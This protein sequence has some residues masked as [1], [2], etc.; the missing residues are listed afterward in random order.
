[1]EGG[2]LAKYGL[3]VGHAGPPVAVLLVRVSHKQGV[4]L[5]VYAD[6]AGVLAAGGAVAHGGGFALPVLSAGAVVRS[7]ALPKVSSMSL[8]CAA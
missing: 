6:V 3:D 4:Q 2:T 5:L 7:C 1:M 8:V